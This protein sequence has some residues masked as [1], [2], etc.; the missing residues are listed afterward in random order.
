MQ[1]IVAHNEPWCV[2]IRVCVRAGAQETRLKLLCDLSCDA[3]WHVQARPV[4][5]YRM[6][7]MFAVERLALHSYAK[8]RRVSVVLL[9]CLST[10]EVVP[11]L[12]L[13]MLR[14]VVK[15]FYS[16]VVVACEWQYVLPCH[17]F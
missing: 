2:I 7:S 1:F 3:C 15:Q 17:S 16:A 14:H 6:H 4:F 12:S 10:V 5:A 13:Q 9:S 11:G 8:L